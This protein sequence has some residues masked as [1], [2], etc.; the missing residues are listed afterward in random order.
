MPNF[1]TLL[2]EQG[3]SVSEPAD[4]KTFSLLLHGLAGSGKSS[5]AATASKVDE[6]S[7]VLYIDFE[8]GTM[9]LAE[10]GDLDNIKIV[11]VSS[12]PDMLR[13]YKNV[14]TPLIRKDEFPFKTIVF[15]TL[16]KMQELVVDHFGKISADG[17]AKWAAAYDAPLELLSTFLYAPGVNVIAITHTAREVNDVTGE[18]LIAP[19]F[20]GKKSGRK[21][22]SLFDFVGYMHWVE[23]EDDK[24]VPVLTTQDQDT[25]AKKRVKDFPANLG[26]PSMEKIFGYISDAV[27]GPANN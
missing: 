1:N 9:P 18:T 26:N 27:D 8:S 2:E 11:H 3:L 13:L 20:E 15:D 6:L 24:L 4:L 19:D 23:T 22:P 10:W 21:F 17:Y 16:D 25:V 14:L 7:P 5:L 12:W